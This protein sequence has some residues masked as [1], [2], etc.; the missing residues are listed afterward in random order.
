[1]SDKHYPHVPHSVPDAI[2]GVVRDCFGAPPRLEQ[3]TTDAALHCLMHRSR[4]RLSAIAGERGSCRDNC[5][6]LQP[7]PSAPKFLAKKSALKKP[8]SAR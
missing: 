8:S 4:P 5:L 6:A 3:R 7:A 2:S 1:V